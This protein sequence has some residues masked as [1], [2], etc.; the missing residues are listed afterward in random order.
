MA[1]QKVKLAFIVNAAARKATYKKRSKSLL[2]KLSELSILCGIDAC[3][4]IY[5]PY[6]PE[7]EIWPTP[8]GVQNVV[9][10]FRRKP[11][12]EQSKKKLSQ[13][14]YLRQRI[15]KAED[16]LRKIR[17]ENRK[18]E[19]KVFTYEYFKQGEIVLNNI[20]LND[21]N[22]L[23]W[24]IDHNLK[25]IGRRLQANGEGQ[26]MIAPTPTPSQLQPQMAPLPL[27]L[28][29]PPPP[30]PPAATASSNNEMATMVS[31]GHAG[32]TA[33]NDDIMQ[34]GFMDLMNGKGDDTLQD[35]FWHNLLP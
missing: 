22:D 32:M 35:G 14:D 18:N 25:D 19:M 9:S 24:F 34:T 30:P 12:F 23:S 13:E 3:A 8:S 26:I 28:P 1:R 16:Q 27:P 33:N 17:N 11:E 29:L 6:E 2:K 5:G 15:V 31:H 20:L 10:K 4:L 7:P 21:L